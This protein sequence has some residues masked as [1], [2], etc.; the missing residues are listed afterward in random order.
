MS[1]ISASPQTVET[2]DYDSPVIPKNTLQNKWHDWDRFLQ[3]HGDPPPPLP[4]LSHAILLP[5]PTSPCWFHCC[6]LH[7]FLLCYLPSFSFP[8]L[9]GILLPVASASLRMPPCLAH[10]HA[11]PHP[12]ACCLPAHFAVLHTHTWERSPPPTPFLHA[13]LHFLHAFIVACCVQGLGDIFP[14]PTTGWAGNSSARQIMCACMVVVVGWWVGT[15]T[16]MDMVMV[17]H[18][19]GEVTVEDRQA[20]AGDWHFGW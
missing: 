11:F 8:H 13:R 20:G 3:R 10:D 12:T 9:P 16:G 5:Y 15:G 19:D 7:T 2:G 1:V 14:Y 4:L 18:G 6:L 17:G